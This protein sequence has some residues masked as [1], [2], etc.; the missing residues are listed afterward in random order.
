MNQE[1]TYNEN[2]LVQDY[3]ELQM[4]PNLIK[5]LGLNY[6]S[7][8][9]N[10]LNSNEYIPLVQLENDP[11]CCGIQCCECCKCCKCC[12]SGS[13]HSFPDSEKIFVL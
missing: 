9:K 11:T 12:V 5:E 10:T 7:D 6:I 1:N 4:E 8:K 13:T 2:L 3:P